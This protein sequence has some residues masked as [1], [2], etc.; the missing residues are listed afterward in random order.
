MDMIPSHPTNDHARAREALAAIPADLPRED[1]VRIGMAAKAAGLDLADFNEWSSTAA[2]RYNAAACRDT[3]KSLHG[4]G[5]IGAGTL[6]H[7]AAAHGWHDRPA[8]E[9]PRPPDT[10]GAAAV[11][12]HC[13]PAPEDHP[14]IVAK[15]GTPAGLRVVPAADSL[16]IA[17]QPLAGALVVPAY[18]TAGNLQSLQFIPAPGQGKKLNLAGATM[19]GAAFTLGE[20]KPGRPC[21]LV[22]GIGQAWACH[23]ATREAAVCCFGWGNVKTIGAALQ[24]PRGPAMV[25]VP[26]VGKE[27]QAAEVAK[28][29]G[30]ALACLPAGLPPNFDVNDYT[31]AEG[32]EALR[33]LLAAVELPEPDRSRPP[34]A[35]SLIPT[36]AEL[37]AARLAPRCIVRH[38]LYADVAALVAPGGTGKTTLLIHEAVHIALGWPVW[39]LPVEAPGWTLF[40]TAEDRREQFMARLREILAC[41]DL[42]P[43]DRARALW[44]VRVWDTTGEAVKLIRAADGNVLLTSLADD[45]VEAY[46]AD[47][48][49]ACVFDP[50]VSFGASEGMINDNEQGIITAARRIVKGL[51]CCVRLVHH[52]GKDNARQVALDQY[53]GRGGSALADGSRMMSVLQTW[54]PEAAGNRQPPPGCTP[55]PEASLTI[56]ARA[57][58][59]YAPPNPPLIWIRREG[60]AFAHFTEEPKPAPE[61]LRAAQAD[62]VERFIR[63]ELERERRYTQ[64]TLE[65]VAGIMSLTRQ[66]LRQAL[67]ELRISGRVIEAPMPKEQCQG[68]RKTYLCPAD[69]PAAPFGGVAPETDENAPDPV[70]TPPPSTTPPPYRGS[71]P[72]GVEPG[73]TDPHPGNPAANDWRGSAGLAEYTES[74]VIEEVLI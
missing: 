14:Y 25:V 6:F 18:G 68:G 9:R 5:G 15:G 13:L 59:S 38:C 64:T 69:N 24:A 57:K 55:G 22:E 4:A 43:A 35:E 23:A 73:F 52:T 72:G 10:P 49:A 27:G 67:A 19:T 29:I 21:Y 71:N 39:G 28:T 20:V 1:W 40:V 32:R 30:A 63:A 61:D 58:L 47:P 70:P 51:S 56:L 2:G 45:I 60:F 62:Q 34:A 7:L 11:W 33:T 12:G 46:Q 44:G 65:A 37:D 31:Q 36:E 41:L 50:L 42:T 48:P 3:W 53:A 54:T 66:T 17:G 8:T 74:K 16:T 26:D